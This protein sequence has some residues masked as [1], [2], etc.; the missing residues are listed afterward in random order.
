MR[1]DRY[2]LSVTTDSDRAAAAYGEGLD[3]VL[4][5][6]TGADAALDR[7][8]VADPGFALAHIARARVH[9]IQGEI[10]QARAAAARARA[11][12]AG[13]TERERG[14][15]AIVADAVEGRPAQARAGAEQHLE[16]HPR[17]ALVLSL[18]LGAFGLYAF[19]GRADHDAAK[20]AILRRHAGQYGDDWWFLTFLGWSHTEAGEVALGRRLSERALELRRANGHGAHGLAHACF[21]QGDAETGR[22][23][24][25]D[26]LPAHDGASILDGHLA[27]HLALL[28]IEADDLDQALAIYRARIQ[29]SVSRAPPMNLLTDAASLLWRVQLAEDRALASDWA[30]VAAFGARAFPRTGVHFADLHQVLIAAAR[31]D[32]A[33]LDRRISE[34]ETLHAEGRLA[35][36]A[37]MLALCRGVRAFATGDD[38]EAI[39]L[40]GPALAEVARV[41][42]SHAQRELFEDTFIVACLRAGRGEAARALVEGRLH[43]RPSDRDRA[44]LRHLQG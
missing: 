37:V 21:E 12:A 36:G 33:A 23:F 2:D 22:G 30:E 9:Q 7:A 25:N 13:A 38:A 44:W 27:W 3:L 41:G 35:P 8:I 39:R 10:A 17:D 19:S 16:A 5:G 18:L 14:H 34:L 24:L 20:L 32:H 6:W 31:G 29:P 42:G 40:I 1:R 26:W 28:A 11:L 43:R 4:S 15:V